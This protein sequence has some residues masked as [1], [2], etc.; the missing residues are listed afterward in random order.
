[1]SKWA[2]ESLEVLNK[3]KAAQEFHPFQER[4]LFIRNGHY[5]LIREINLRETE[6]ARVEGDREREGEREYQAGSTLSAQ[7]LTWGSNPPSHEIV[8]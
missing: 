2:G 3:A 6:T 7:I 4:S 8:T 5:I 1:M